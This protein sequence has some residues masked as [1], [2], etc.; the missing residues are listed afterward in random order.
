MTH[1]ELRRW[2]AAHA[3]PDMSRASPE[4]LAKLAKITAAFEARYVRD[5]LAVPE[6][7]PVVG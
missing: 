2:V 5:L 4:Q 6:Y 1:A 3:H 7:R